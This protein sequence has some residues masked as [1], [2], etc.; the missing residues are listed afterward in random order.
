MSDNMSIWKEAYQLGSPFLNPKCTANIEKKPLSPEPR[1]QLC[2]LVDIADTSTR[3]L[4]VYK[5]PTVKREM[6]NAQEPLFLA[7]QT[8]I[9]QCPDVHHFAN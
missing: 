3:G 2:H 5:I 1:R 7:M 4:Y 8:V 9:L 6:K